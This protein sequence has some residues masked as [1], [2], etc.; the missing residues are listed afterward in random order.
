VELSNLTGW[1]WLVLLTAIASVTFGLW[2]GLVRTAAGLA[3]WV[4]AFLL[5]PLGAGMLAS[6]LNSVPSWVQLALAFLIFFILIQLLGAL[7]AR[8]V[9][10]VGLGGVDRLL[11]AVLGL[12]RALAIVALLATASIAL[13]FDQSAAWQSA[14]S[15]GMLE[16]LVDQVYGRIGERLPRRGTPGKHATQAITHVDRRN[17]DSPDSMMIVR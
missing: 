10:G 2:R 12:A 7:L 11:G 6:M 13:G 15:R 3:A 16:A 5:A 4:G 8:L 17:D 14:R 9:R 1:D